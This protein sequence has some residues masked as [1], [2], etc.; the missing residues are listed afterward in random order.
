MV[1]P[2]HITLDPTRP[3]ADAA[4]VDDRAVPTHLIL[5]IEDLTELHRL[6]TMRQDFVSHVSHELRTP[7]AALK[8]LA[9]TLGESIESDPQAAREFSKRISGEIDHLSQMVA[10]LL[11]L[12]SIETGRLHLKREPT[13]LNGLIEVVQDR[14]R[15]LADANDIELGLEAAEDLPMASVDGKRISEVLVNLIHN[16]L[17]YTPGG[18][19]V[20]VSSEALLGHRLLAV[21][22]ADT[23]VGINEEDLPRVFE[24]F[25]KAD[26]AR[27]R[28]IDRQL[29]GRSAPPTSPDDPDDPDEKLWSDG[30]SIPE[31]SAAAGTGL[32]LAISKHLVE[33]HGGTIWAESRLGCGSKFSFTVPMATEKE[34]AEAEDQLSPSTVDA[35]ASTMLP[36]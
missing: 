4:L 13:D 23:G 9:E 31:T 10:E 6:E 34:L 1:S 24:R 3:G 22:V 15:P 20:T 25:F 30:L 33:L 16:A 8:L 2:V 19:R 28:S 32:G 29:H 26:R 18:G 36:S 17:K 12:A 14:M 7:L 21:H 5:A 27:T 11:E 35:I